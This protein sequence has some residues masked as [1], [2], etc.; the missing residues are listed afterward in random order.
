MFK[1][2]AQI[3]TISV[4]LPSPKKIEANQ[5]ALEAATEAEADLS[6]LQKQQEDTRKR[7]IRAYRLAG[8]SAYNGVAFEK[9]GRCL[10][11]GPRIRRSGSRCGAMGRSRNSNRERGGRVDHRL[12]KLRYHD[13]ER[14]PAARALR[15]FERAVQPGSFTAPPSICA[16][17]DFQPGVMVSNFSGTLCSIRSGRVLENATMH[18]A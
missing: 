17:Q 12:I 13:C 9:S 14:R 5:R 18:N 3:H 11:Q 16:A 7:A 6:N 4:W 8:D 2:E 15:S 10:W 1:L